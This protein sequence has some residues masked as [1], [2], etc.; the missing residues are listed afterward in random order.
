MEAQGNPDDSAAAAEAAIQ[1]RIDAAV[2]AALAN[3]APVDIP[4][5]PLDDNRKV[6]II[7]EENDNIPP[8]GQFFGANGRSYLVRPGEEVDVPMEVI[9]C[10]DDAVMETPITDMAGN[11]EGFRKRLRF[12]YRII[13]QSV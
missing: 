12:P 10:L 8:T 2:A 4:A 3:Q 1:A 13:S 7:L 6:R 9:S 5:P 11:I